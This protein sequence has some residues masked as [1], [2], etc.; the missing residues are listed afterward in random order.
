MLIFQARKEISAAL[1]GKV[2]VIA[3]QMC[4]CHE[5]LTLPLI[6]VL[7]KIMRLRGVILEASLKSA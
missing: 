2:N 7:K 4:D 5:R 1:H 3:A 6:M